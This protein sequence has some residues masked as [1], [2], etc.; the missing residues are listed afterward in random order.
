[1]K[2]EI[3]FAR[4]GLNSDDDYS[5]IPL[6]DSRER[7]NVIPSENGNLGTI[8]NIKGNKRLPASSDIGYVLE[9]KERNEILAF[10][11]SGYIWA[12]KLSS[13]G[14]D[15]VSSRRIA[16]SV[17]DLFSV[18]NV[19]LENLPMPSTFSAEIIGDY[20]IC[21]NNVSEPK[22][23]RLD[24]DDIAYGSGAD[25][26]VYAL[27]RPF[28]LR[29]DR[30]YIGTYELSDVSLDE[31]SFYQFAISLEYK[32]NEIT[33]LTN[34]SNVVYYNNVNSSTEPINHSI[35]YFFKPKE[36]ADLEFD[37]RIRNV[38]IYVRKNL[39]ANFVLAKSFD[40]YDT[41][42]FS[43]SI[44]R[45]GFSVDE[46]E[47]TFT[48]RGSNESFEVINDDLLFSRVP[49]ASKTLAVAENKLIFGNNLIGYDN[50]S[51]VDDMS[52]LLTDLGYINYPASP[53]PSPSVTATGVGT[54]SVIIDID[55]T[56]A[57]SPA[58]IAANDKYIDYVIQV[59]SSYDV[60]TTED[61][62]KNISVNTSNQGYP[63]PYVNG[64]YIG[65]T[66]GALSKSLNITNNLDAVVSVSTATAN[67]VKVIFTLN[68]GTVSTITE[69]SVEPI[70]V[71]YA[72]NPQSGSY[73]MDGSTYSVCMYFFDSYGRTAGGVGG[74]TLKIPKNYNTSLLGV[75]ENKLSGRYGV[76]QWSNLGIEIPDWAKTCSFGISE[77]VEYNG[78]WVTDVYYEPENAIRIS[79]ENSYGYEFKDGDIIKYNSSSS[80]DPILSKI[81]GFKQV[82]NNDS[83][84]WLL[85]EDGFVNDPNQ[86]KTILR[87]RDTKQGTQYFEISKR[88]EIDRS[89]TPKIIGDIG[90][91][92]GWFS[93]GD[94][95]LGNEGFFLT[96]TDKWAANNSGRFIPKIENSTQNRIQNLLYSEKYFDNTKVN[97]LS[98]FYPESVEN[99]D[100]TFGEINK[101][102]NIGGVVKL[103]QENKRTSIYIERAQL[104]DSTN[105]S[106][107][108]IISS[109]FLG[110]KEQSFTNYGTKFPNSVVKNQRYI[111]FYDSER[112][113]V[114]RDSANG[115][116]PISGR[117][118]TAEGS[119]DYKMDKFFKDFSLDKVN[120]ELAKDNIDVHMS[121][122]ESND[123]LFIYF[124]TKTGE[125]YKQ[126]AFHEPT[127]R[128]VSFYDMYQIENDITGTPQPLE[129]T[130]PRFS[131]NKGISYYTVNGSSIWKHNS[132]SVRRCNFYGLQ[133]GMSIDV[134]LSAPV[135]AEFHGIE[136][137]STHRFNN[138]IYLPDKP[139]LQSSTL[140][141]SDVPESI[142][143]GSLSAY[144]ISEFKVNSPLIATVVLDVTLAA[145]SSVAK[146]RCY[147]GLVSPLWVYDYIDIPSTGVYTFDVNLRNAD[148]D[149]SGDNS[150]LQVL[151]GATDEMT[152]NSVS[153]VYDEVIENS[154]IKSREFRDKEGLL[155]STYYRDMNS[156]LNPVIARLNGDRLRGHSI[157]NRLSLDSAPEKVQIQSASITLRGSRN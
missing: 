106:N 141:S 76:V 116:F 30:A 50:P 36:F 118:S 126:L 47:F 4:T 3:K 41:G 61:P 79:P 111:Y 29:S 48:Y 78:S 31:D 96:K 64:A 20:V 92:K 84:G 40:P 33:P 10:T 66:T 80:E 24:L 151:V 147:S 21:T 35:K 8:T 86:L 15:I 128:W 145:T 99:I 38:N 74:I 120:K 136:I 67:H 65:E 117:F 105:N 127:N 143:T 112:G 102:I 51:T 150:Y 44:T 98:T 1:M 97:G 153:I 12:Y 85:L 114:V 94:F 124:Y 138:S 7:L 152:V 155:R 49:N 103:Y 132:D 53:S 110:S 72:F 2:Q 60:T 157:V 43:D 5:L 70:G 149:G 11:Y 57:F 119:V 82:V 46:Y 140:F 129:K 54:N 135:L 93:A 73:L 137:D 104:M 131:F 34:Y 52:L 6:G 90:D 18:G 142:P 28:I 134:D 148:V 107:L 133:K 130:Y 108:G 22:R 88:Y 101:I 146:A 23:F 55:L 13:D 62:L 91:N 75:L 59:V 42:T 32:T 27:N 25:E 144:T 68:S 122:D 14:E 71:R 19:D 26:E 77:C 87:I 156:K 17:V 125:S 123:L 81:I 45:D 56:N 83:S 37:Y 9:D 121:Y 39:S 113:A 69:S 58:F 100:D 63:I 154:N 89:S 109:R 115:L 16:S 139:R 95:V